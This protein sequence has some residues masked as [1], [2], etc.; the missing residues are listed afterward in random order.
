MG[1]GGL[2]TGA[3]PR[4]RLLSSSLP[5]IRSAWLAAAESEAVAKIEA[6]RA[7]LAASDAEIWTLDYGAGSPREAL[8]A[9]QMAEGRGRRERIGDLC[10]KRSATRE[11]CLFLFRIVRLLRPR[12]CLELGTSLGLSAAYIGSALRL[13]G[14]GSLISIEGCPR[15]AE[16]AGEN[17][18]RLELENV[19]VVAGR[20]QDSLPALLAA[21]AF[22]FAYVDGH[23][24][25]DATLDYVERIAAAGAADMV[26]AIDDIDWSE[27][28][29]EAWARIA[30]SPRIS[31]CGSYEGLGLC[32]TST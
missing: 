3:S 7:E 31:A 19:S 4:G 24:D 12:R 28:M 8:S 22:D 18:R 5:V 11:K 26:I 23:H 15:L 32:F 1:M 10:R 17:L 6:L 13:N 2:A 25:R 20:F 27:G 30:Q 29:R 21:E 14:A 9:A 16:L